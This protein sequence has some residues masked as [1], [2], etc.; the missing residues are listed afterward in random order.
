MKITDIIEELN[1]QDYSSFDLETLYQLSLKYDWANLDLE[2]I[3]PQIENASNYARNIIMLDPMEVVVLAWPPGVQSA[4]HHH[5]G[6]WGVVAVIKGELENKSFKL[7]EGELRES[8]SESG[9]PGGLIRED[10]GVIH[11]LQNP[12]DEVAVSVHLYCPP[13]VDF[14]GMKIFDLEKG[15]IGVLNAAAQ[16]ASWEEPVSSFKEIQEDT[17]RYIPLANKTDAPS[18]RVHPVVPKPDTEAIAE[19]IGEYYAEQAHNYDHFD[20]THESRSR[21]TE[22]VNHLVAKDLEGKSKLNDLLDIA[23]G[24]GRR[25]VEIQESSGCEYRISGVDLSSEMCDIAAA[26]GIR[27]Y[28]DKWL[29]VNLSD[30][31]FDAISFLYAFGH[32]ATR[33]ERILG[34]RKMWNHL[35]EGGRLYFDVFNV[36]DVTEWGPQAVRLFDRLRLKDLGYERGDVFYKKTGGKATAFIHYF[37]DKEIVEILEEAGFRVISIDHIGYTRKAGELLSTQEEGAL[38]VIAKKVKES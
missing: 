18:H 20:T 33:E 28:N 27:T 2:D 14:D 13:L 12:T 17:F 38:F 16:T 26:R 8:V 37:S 32:I 5:V 35:E 21:Y 7:T 23:C 25:A 15:R 11:L 9:R 29:D 19:L 3:E 34:L 30:R 31:S 22:K 1:S 4:I 10:D 24:T 36:K 6:F